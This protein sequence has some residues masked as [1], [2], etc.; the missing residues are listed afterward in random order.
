MH[1][2]TFL[3][4]ILSTFFTD[5]VTIHLVHAPSAYQLLSLRYVVRVVYTFTEKCLDNRF[6]HLHLLFC[7]HHYIIG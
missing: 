2:M 5:L 7:Y 1:W 4:M 3:R 6:Y